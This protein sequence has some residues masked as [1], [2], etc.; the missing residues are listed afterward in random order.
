M[1]QG[2]FAQ[3]IVPGYVGSQKYLEREGLHVLRGVGNQ[4]MCLETGEMFRPHSHTD[5][6][7]WVQLKSRLVLEYKPVKDPKYS[8]FSTEDR[9]HR[10]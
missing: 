8:T 2:Q 4:F 7:Y 6:D 5:I 10:S 9:E 1:K 3:I